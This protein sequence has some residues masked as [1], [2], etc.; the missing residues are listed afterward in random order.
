MEDLK[1]SKEDSESCYSD[2]DLTSQMREKIRAQASRLRSLEQYRLLCEQRI[3]ELSPGHTLPIKPEH[4]GSSSPSSELSQARNKIVQLESLLDKSHK[5]HKGNDDEDYNDLLDK[6]NSLIKD[7]TDLEASLRAEMLTCE[8]QR[9]YIEVL[10]QAIES[11]TEHASTPLPRPEQ[12]RNI[13]VRR[14]PRRAH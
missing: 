7:K 6:Y 8:E 3:Q 12:R 2:T 1:K 13:P 5:S 9:T 4:L 11:K 14:R 10:K